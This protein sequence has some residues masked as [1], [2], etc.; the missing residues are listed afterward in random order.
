MAAKKKTTAKGSKKK[1]NLSEMDQ[2][3]GKTEVEFEPST[4][5]QV[6][7]N[8]GLET[9]GTNDEVKYLEMLNGM[10]KVDMQE[11]ATK[12]GLIPI[13]N[14]DILRGRLVKE[15]KK[16]QNAYRRPKKVASREIKLSKNIKDILGEGK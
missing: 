12:V 15:F 10:A 6:W 8:D 1:L 13:D 14:I 3:H 16:H 4:L 5:E 7:G 11:H 2:T 9:Y